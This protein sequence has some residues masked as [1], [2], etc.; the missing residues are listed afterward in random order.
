[1][2]WHVIEVFRF[3]VVLFCPLLCSLYRQKLV[4]EQYAK[5]FD[6]N[7]ALEVKP[8]FF[9][10]Y[11]FLKALLD[12]PL[13]NS[14]AVSQISAAQLWF[15]ESYQP[16]YKRHVSNLNIIMQILL[17]V[18]LIFLMVH[19]LV[20]RVWFNIKTMSLSSSETQGELD[21]PFAHGNPV[22]PT[23]HPWSPRMCHF[24]WLLPSFSWAVWLFL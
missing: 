3:K 17:T 7:E 12:R 19:V 8:Y 13:S 2:V 5:I 11:L 16:F 20:K 18:L 23:S 15:W 4:C 6:T 24:W 14:F 22:V 9:Y 21:F 1:M 10:N